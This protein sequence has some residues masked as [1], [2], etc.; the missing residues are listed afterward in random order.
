MFNYF[1]QS[2]YWQYL[3]EQSLSPTLPQNRPTLFKIRPKLRYC[4]VKNYY[5]IK[6]FKMMKKK[7]WCFSLQEG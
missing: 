1:P 6:T 3:I 7:Y 2:H 4:R 5:F